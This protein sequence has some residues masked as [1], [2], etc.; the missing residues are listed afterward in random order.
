MSEDNTVEAVELVLSKPVPVEFSENALKVRRNLLA[1]S[2]VIVV[3]QLGGAGLAP[4]APLFGFQFTALTTH[5]INLGL[6]GITIYLAVHFFFYVVESFMEWRL[7]LTGCR[8]AFITGTR[9]ES[10]HKDIPDDP[11]QSTLYNWWKEHASQIGNIPARLEVWDSKMA[12]S[13]KALRTLIAEPHKF[14]NLNNALQL[15]SETVNSSTEINRSVQRARETL[16]ALRIPSS[17]ERFDKWFCWFL[18]IE[19]FRWLLVDSLFPLLLAGYAILLLS[20]LV[21]L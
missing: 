14:E 8:V 17:L 1:V 7:R 3:M 10:P 12:E 15:L 20:H 6:L 2:T 11:R 9:Y 5:T 18:R 21:K 4:N 16:E 13:D 19:N